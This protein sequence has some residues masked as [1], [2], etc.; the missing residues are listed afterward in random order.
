MC[1]S[2]LFLMHNHK[3]VKMSKRRSTSSL[4]AFQEMR[5]FKDF[6]TIWYMNRWDGPVSK[7]FAPKADSICSIPT[8]HMVEGHGWRK[9]SAPAWCLLNS[10]LAQW[11]VCD[12][13][14][15]YIYTLIKLNLMWFITD[16][17]NHHA[18]IDLY[19]VIDI[20]HDESHFKIHLFFFQRKGHVIL[21]TVKKKLPK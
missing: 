16:N 10:I 2:C 19:I 18:C 5:A 8:A 3:I 20:L 9:E 12:P 21:P 4:S 6:L 13:I 14:H 17:Y 7:L 1:L 11:H 15:I